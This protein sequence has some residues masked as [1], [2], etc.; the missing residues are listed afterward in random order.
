[1]AWLSSNTTQKS[2]TGPL[3]PRGRKHPRISIRRLYN[4]ALG[5][6]HRQVTP[7]AEAWRYCSKLIMERKRHNAR[8]YLPG[9]EIADVG[10]STGEGSA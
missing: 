2:W 6:W 5:R 1:M 8:Y 7:H 10:C 3:Q 4:Q 9:Q